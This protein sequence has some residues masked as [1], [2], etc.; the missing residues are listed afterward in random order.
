MTGESNSVLGRQ[1]SPLR[2]RRPPRL[3]PALIK[4]TYK[5]A[6]DAEEQID[7]ERPTDYDLA[8]AH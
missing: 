4:K 1:G 8:T 5:D 2:P 6:E 3:I 7:G